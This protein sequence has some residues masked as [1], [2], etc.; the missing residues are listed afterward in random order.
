MQLSTAT[1]TR[2]RELGWSEETIARIEASPLKDVTVANIAMMRIPEERVRGFLDLVDRD[3]ERVPNLTFNLIRTRSERGVRAK[4]SERGLL[5]KD[6]NIG[7]YGQVPDHWP[8]ENDTP[9]G[10]H[11][12]P[13]NYAPGSYYIYDKV[14]VWAEGVDE[15]YEDAIRD[16]WAPATELDWNEGLAELPAEIEKA[17]C[18]LATLYSG[19]GLVEQKILAKWLEPISYGFHDVKLFLGTQ[20]YDAGHKVEALR[21]RALANGGGLG[22]A[23]LGALYRA[24]YGA[25]KFTEM[26]TAVDVVYKSYELTLFEAYGD[27][28]KTEVERKLFS[29]L[30]RDSRRHLEYGKR[31]LLWYV[32][33]HPRGRENVRFWLGRAEAAL[34]IELRY[35]HAEREALALLFAGDME[36]IQAGIERLGKLREK[37]LHDYIGVLDEV[38][39]DRLPQ[40]SPH[41]VAIAEN[42]LAV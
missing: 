42:P 31:H 37:Q 1:K 23:P 22:Q 27:F 5:L 33:H 39:I 2:A 8:Y 28:A 3:P 34:S 6:I 14:E 17:V 36:R 7:T 20:I 25:L 9:R 30:A 13:D 40:V 38:G 18:Q 41:L 10:A 21:K 19:H 11:P 16:R 12:S 35:S 4:P 32:Q 29:L 24:W 15:L 26:I